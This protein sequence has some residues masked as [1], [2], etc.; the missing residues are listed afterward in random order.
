[1]TSRSVDP[2]KYGDFLCKIFDEWVQR[3]VGEVFVQ[4]FDSAL[5]STLGVPSVCIHSPSCGLNL[6]T[7]FN[8]DVYTCDHW[9]EPNWRIGSVMTESFHKMVNTETMRIFSKK[10]LGLLSNKCKTCP[11]LA[12]CW[13]GCPKDRF[14]FLPDDEA[15]QN[16]LCPGYTRLYSHIMPSIYRMK[17]LI[18]E[19][20]PA[21]LIMKEHRKNI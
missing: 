3:D 5:G 20:K 10:K 8:G 18:R 13:G 16:Y 19:G 15:E 7:E 14:V 11:F 1:M 17:N 21:A 12:V 4:D 6:A 9:V 2:Q